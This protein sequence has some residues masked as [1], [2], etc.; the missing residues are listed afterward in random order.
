V[1]SSAPPAVDEIHVALRRRL[2]FGF[3]FR[4]AVR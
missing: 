3:L 1:S 4:A 2:G